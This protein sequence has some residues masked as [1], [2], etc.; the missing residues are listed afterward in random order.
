MG[1]TPR[2]LSGCQIHQWTR[3]VGLI[4]SPFEG[5]CRWFLSFKNRDGKSTGP[6]W[7]NSVAIRKWRLGVLFQPLG[8][9]W[10]KSFDYPT[11]NYQALVA[12]ISHQSCWWFRNP[13][14][15]TWHA[16]NN[17]NNGTNYQPQLVSRISSIN[18]SSHQGCSHSPAVPRNSFWSVWR[19]WVSHTAIQ[20]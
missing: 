7:T 12:T 2:F 19:C 15:T 13:A 5:F 18:N 11:C 6:K 8:W 4:G 16:L 3:K 10:P 14:I 20:S 17:V 9:G 1:G